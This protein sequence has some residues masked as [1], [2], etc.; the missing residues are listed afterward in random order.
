MGAMW[1]NIFNAI[2]IN[3]SY[4]MQCWHLIIINKIIVLLYNQCF[5]ISYHSHFPFRVRTGKLNSI[6]LDLLRTFIVIAMALYVALKLFMLTHRIYLTCIFHKGLHDYYTE[7]NNNYYNI[8]KNYHS[9]YWI[10]LILII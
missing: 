2:N 4:W 9:N 3:S 1:K 8:I 10:A 5:A 6:H 7:F